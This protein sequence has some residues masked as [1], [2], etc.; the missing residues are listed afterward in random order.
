[1]RRIE[2]ELRTEVDSGRLPIVSA[3]H[4]D[5][6]STIRRFY[7]DT[8]NVLDFT[9]VVVSRIPMR[10]RERKRRER[11]MEKER[12]NNRERK[13]R[14]GR[15]D[16][17]G[18]VREGKRV[19]PITAAA[20]TTERDVNQLFPII[21]PHRALPHFCSA[22]AV[23]T[24][25]KRTMNRA[26]DGGPRACVTQNILTNNKRILEAQMHRDLYVETKSNQAENWCSAFFRL[27]QGRQATNDPNRIHIQNAFSAIHISLL[28]FVN[29]AVKG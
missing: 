17:G 1:M 29:F 2:W 18:G 22:F 5:D 26:R 23:S 19:D 15:E 11:G 24:R 6:D 3:T 14:R 21:H 25:D 12:E 9:A 27:T 16:G 28:N 10:R 8:E 13:E 7:R 20:V 4:Y